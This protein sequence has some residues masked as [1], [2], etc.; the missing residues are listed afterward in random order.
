MPIDEVIALLALPLWL[1]VIAFAHDRRIGKIE[2][3]IAIEK[4]GEQKAP[5]P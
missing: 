3:A 4:L 1:L 2:K 5:C